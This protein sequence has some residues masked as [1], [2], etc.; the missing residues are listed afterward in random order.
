M[1]RDKIAIIG[2]G[3]VGSTTAYALML[4]N[5]VAEICLVD[6]DEK[7]CRGEIDD[8][9]DALP[10]CQTSQICVND[11][12]QARDARIIIIA[13]GVR[14]KPNQSR[15]E[16]LS[17]NRSILSSIIKGLHPL[18]HESILLIISNPVDVLTMCAQEMSGLPRTHVFGSGT[19]LDSQ[20]LRHL[21][22]QEVGIAEQSIDAYILGEHGDTQFPAWSTAHIDG[23]PINE[24]PN[25]T[26]QK[27]NDLAQKTRNKAYE[28]IACKGATF[29]GIATC[30]ASICESI[31]YNQKRVIPVSCFIEELG[32][33]L[34]MPAVIG[35]NGIEQILPAALNAQEN[36]LLQKSAQR[37]RELRNLCA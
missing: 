31:V 11:L 7:R 18:S 16:L 4:K 33:C 19:F 32:V 12:T 34:S 3:S 26:S 2:A 27:L 9:V 14:Q 28:I 10:F 5:V 30:V 1:V 17:T 22:A 13:A 29:Y 15:E 6:I 23:I 21:I 8:L 35:L 36:E 24:F 25:L 20:R 37:L